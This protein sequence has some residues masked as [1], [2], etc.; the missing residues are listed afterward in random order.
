MVVMV[1]KSNDHTEPTKSNAK[2]IKKLLS[3][4]KAKES[5][6]K[7]IFDFWTNDHVHVYNGLSVMFEI[8]YRKHINY[9]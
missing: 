5:W 9:K 6:S 7:L 2:K 4:T 3:S 8:P 1:K